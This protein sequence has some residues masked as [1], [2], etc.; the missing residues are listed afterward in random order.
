M[1]AA[2]EI[3]AIVASWNNERRTVNLDPIRIGISITTGTVI[4]GIVGDTTRMEYTIIGD[5][6]NLAAKLDKQCKVENCTI[7][8]TEDALNLAVK[9]GFSSREHSRILNNRS[10]AGVAEPVNLAIIK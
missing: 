2:L 5:P 6:V 7:L 9:Q 3:V 4:L 1:R 8:A 10:V